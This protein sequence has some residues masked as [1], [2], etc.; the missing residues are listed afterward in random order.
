MDTNR[1]TVIIVGGGIAGLVAARRIAD[2]YNTIILEA[3]DRLGGRIYS[4]KSNK[5][6][7]AIEGGSEFIHGRLK[8]TMGLLK[9]AGIEHVP[10]E[11]KFYRKEKGEWKEQHEFI[12]GWDKL[13]HHM[14]KIKQD[15]TM[16]DFLQ[17]HFGDDK[18]AD[19]RRH[20]I[21]FTEGFDVADIKKVSVRFLYNEWSHEEESFRIPGGY[22]RLI[23]FLASE[24]EKK[25]C[26]IVLNDPVKQIDWQKDDVTVYT[27]KTNKYTGNKT[28][29]TIPV[30]VLQMAN[31]R[32]SIN[33]TP[34]LDDY[35]N[36]A[37]QT[38]FGTV[39]KMILEF[40]NGFWKKDTGFILSDAIIPTWWTQLPDTVPLLT[41]W[42]A[43]SR[44][45]RLNNESDESLLEK[46]LLSLANIFEQTEEQLRKNLVAHKIFNWQKNNYS[47]GAYSYSMPDSEKARELLNTPIDNTIYFAGEGL[48][49]GHSPGT[50]EA[51]IVNA[52]EMT[53]KLMKESR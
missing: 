37:R 11:G 4:C 53:N 9:E 5:F 43:G 2:S 49:K 29:V 27:E 48:Y 40:K 7:S 30:S 22:G 24:C 35:V 1:E 13:L 36:A 28:I 25:G 19:L 31:S 8:E 20:A 39:I 50:V 33:F 21:A 15:T 46:G 32:A 52:N 26:K 47:L 14:E 34:P 6:S 12:E 23:Q 3:D 41:G 44:A 18:Y 42:T 16:A 10:V 45:E 51:A 17:Q 38:G